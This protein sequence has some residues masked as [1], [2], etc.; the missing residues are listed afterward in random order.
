MKFLSLKLRTS[1]IEWFLCLKPWKLK[2]Y[3]SMN[4]FKKCHLEDKEEIGTHIYFSS[5]V[6]DG[7]FPVDVQLAIYKRW[8]K[9]KAHLG[10][11]L[12]FV[13]KQLSKQ[14]F[15]SMFD[16]KIKHR[17]FFEILKVWIALNLVKMRINDCKV[18]T[19][20]KYRT[21]CN[22]RRSSN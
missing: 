19:S 9:V 4:S 10:L 1:K 18:H 22:R 3:K 21:D 14:V 17:K 12:A 13:K 20:Y 16:T 15:F 7:I 8:P 6:N 2:K 11:Y 5:Y